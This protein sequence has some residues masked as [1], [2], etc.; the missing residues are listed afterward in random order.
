MRERRNRK[1][2]RVLLAVFALCV[3]AAIGTVAAV[4]WGRRVDSPE[5]AM[6]R[7]ANISE[8]IS[9]N[10][11]DR[12]YWNDFLKYTSGYEVLAATVDPNEWVSPSGWICGSMT[13]DDICAAH[14]VEIQSSALQKLNCEGIPRIYDEW[15]FWETDRD[16]DLI[17]DWEF[18]AGL[19]CDG[20]LLI[21]RGHHM[22][23]I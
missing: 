14:Q 2:L 9:L 23:F 8:D 3:T 16:S 15:F 18:L 13:I 21:Y 1:I 22:Y 6:L 5:A 12:V 4:I 19:Y 7:R 10:V 17:D 11:V 20:F